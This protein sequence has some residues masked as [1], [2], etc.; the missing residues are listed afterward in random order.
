MT[1]KLYPLPAPRVRVEDRTRGLGKMEWDAP[2]HVAATF[3]VGQDKGKRPANRRGICK[4]EPEKY[5][6]ATVDERFRTMRSL[7]LQANGASPRRFGASRIEQEGWY[8][9]KKRGEHSAAYTIFHDDR[10]RGEKTEAQFKTMMRRVAAGVSAVLCQ[11]E[12]LVVFD[13]PDGKSTES[14]SADPA[15]R[16]T[17]KTIIRRR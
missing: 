15:D 11:D 12:V 16:K 1:T 9:G 6:I 17:A 8:K 13:V 5:P 3:Y 2:R 7:V 4:T 10:V 14:Y